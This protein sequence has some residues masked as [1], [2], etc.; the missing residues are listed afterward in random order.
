MASF[1][2]LA[3]VTESRS[4][5]TARESRETEDRAALGRQLRVRPIRAVQPGV[6]VGAAELALKRLLA[7]TTGTSGPV[8]RDVLGNRTGKAQRRPFL[9]VATTGAVMH[10]GT[11]KR[12]RRSALHLIIQNIAEHSVGHPLP[13]IQITKEMEALCRMYLAT[14]EQLL[15]VLAGDRLIL[16]DVTPGRVPA[17]LARL[18]S[19]DGIKLE[20]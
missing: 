10:P 9:N 6:T 16:E 13:P 2:D 19:E 12:M 1:G 11:S 17:W 14:F 7:T 8:A 18:L 5:R 4:T 3:R 15:P 20:A